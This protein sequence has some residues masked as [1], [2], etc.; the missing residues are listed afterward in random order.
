MLKQ[1]NL[2]FNAIDKLE[3]GIAKV[4]RAVGSTMGTGG[5]N[6]ILEAIENPGHLTTNDGYSIANSIVLADPIEDMGRKILLEAINRANKASGDGSS[7]T[8]VLTA[9]ILDEGRKVVNEHHPMDIK[10]SLEECLPLIEASLKE[11]SR[12]VTVDNVSQ[13][14][15]ISAEDEAIGKM[16]GDIYKEIGPKGIIYWDISKT[17]NDQYTIG[18]GITV[19]DAGFLSPYMCDATENGQSTNQI[20]IKD[21]YILIS[22]QKIASASDF[23]EIA[24]TLHSQEVRDLVVFCEDIDPLVV[25]D[26]IKTRMMRG[27]RIAIVKMPVLWKDWWYEDLAQAT[28][29]TVVDP[30]AGLPLKNMKLEHL[31]RVGNIVITKNETHLDGIAD[32]SDHIKELEAE[33]TDEALLRASRLNTK[34]A[35]YFVGAQS[36][37][38][39]SYRRLKVEDAISAAYQALN[40]GIVAGGGSALASVELPDT[41]GGH[42]LTDALKAPAKQIA[43]N[44]GQIGMVIGDDYKGGKGFDTRSGSFVNMFDA[45][46]VD[47]TNIVLNAIKN[48]ISV[49]A[50]I[51]T[52]PTLVTLPREENDLNQLSPSNAIVR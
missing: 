2:H 34:T 40:G 4:A 28:G 41:I 1:D 46:I 50:T 9:A 27:F 36:D 29:A 22:K 23:N 7:T 31:G 43:F 38:A 26:I 44:A 6:A 51:L 52:A 3:T 37:S 14:A 10:R 30:A 42:I 8:C 12:E 20:R 19:D 15:S 45:G 13:V 18:Q 35:R 47:P 39:L 32:V 5:G 48:A 21:P 17:A 16:I 25:P 24:S 49:A 33:G 11:Q